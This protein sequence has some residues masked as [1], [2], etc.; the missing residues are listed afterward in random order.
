MSLLNVFPD[1]D[2][3]LVGALVFTAIVVVLLSRLG[4]LPKKSLPYIGA[5]L[6]GVIGLGVFRKW[7]SSAERQA[8]EDDRNR[9]RALEPELEEKRKRFQASEDAYRQVQAEIDR[10]EEALQRRA[11]LAEAEPADRDTVE[12]LS[13]EEVFERYRRAFPQ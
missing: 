9:L 3:L 11:L 6:L 4:F 5:T 12:Q 8:L 7:R 1:G 13:A 2:L 10:R